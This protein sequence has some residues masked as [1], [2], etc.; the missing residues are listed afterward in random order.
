MFDYRRPHCLSIKIVVSKSLQQDESDDFKCI[1]NLISLINL[2]Y[3]IDTKSDLESNRQ[4]LM[5]LIRLEM[6]ISYF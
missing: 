5:R 3:E 6:V 4:S 1:K 2:T